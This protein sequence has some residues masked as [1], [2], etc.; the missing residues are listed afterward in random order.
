MQPLSELS[1]FELGRIKLVSFDADG[2]TVKKGTKVLEKDNKLSVETEQI[3]Q[4]ILQKINRLKKKFYIN[5][6]SGRSLVYLNR[7][8]GQILWHKA[9]LQGENGLFTLING[10]VLQHDK[11]TFQELDRVEEIRQAIRELAI[12]DK[13]IKGFEP[14]QFLITVHCSRE[15][16]QILD[17]VRRIDKSGE[18][19]TYWNNEAY[20]IFLKRFTK[21][22]GLEFLARHLGIKLSEVLFVGN[23][24][25]DNSIVGK[26]GLSVTTDRTRLEADFYTE[27]ELEVG[28]EEV[29]DRL[30]QCGK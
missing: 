10:E 1:D 20:D 23:D 17:I 28:G 24:L 13:N 9:S 29:V 19:Y 18:F 21:G 6:T 16:P 2:V 7:I 22:A 4:T 8:Y 27:R 12:S 5:I 30:L 11:L 14:K 26:A 3:S 25:N 15:E